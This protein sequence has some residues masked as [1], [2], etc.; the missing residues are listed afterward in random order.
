MMVFGSW[1][2]LSDSGFLQ[3]IKTQGTVSMDTSFIFCGVPVA[4]EE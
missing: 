4:W 2:A 1:K 3:M